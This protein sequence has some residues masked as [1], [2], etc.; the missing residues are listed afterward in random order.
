M[1]ERHTICR[2]CSALCPIVAMIENGKLVSA[3][4]KT[5]P[6]L[7]TNYSCQKL[8]AAPDIVYSA[9]RLKKPLI[10]HTSG[11]NRGWKEASWPQALD[12][13]ADKLKDLKLRHG[14][15]TVCWMRGMAADWGAPWD[16]AVRFMNTLGSP[17]A[18]GNGSV[19]HVAREFAHVVTYG[20]MT[21]ADYRNAKCI[22]IFGKNDRDTNPPAYESILFA[23]NDGAK[24]IV[25]DPVRTQL[26]E[27]ADVWLQIKPG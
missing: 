18:I 3:E 6:G 17:N 25:V 1:D 7:E 4:R 2:L 10:K 20:A 19:C 24:L 26:S 11:S 13:I 5:P 22:L 14:A 9:K 16:Y 12:W 15:E 21:S 27:M 23:K 8:E